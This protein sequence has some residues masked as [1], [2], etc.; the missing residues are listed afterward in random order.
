MAKDEKLVKARKKQ[1]YSQ[2]SLGK[3]L[4]ISRITINRIENRKY[5]NVSRDTI[6]K[7]RKFLGV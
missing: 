6:L 4:G 7:V 3:K 5:D 2:K 1:G